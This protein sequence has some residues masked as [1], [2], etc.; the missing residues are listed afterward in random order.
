MSKPKQAARCLPLNFDLFHEINEYCFIRNFKNS[1]RQA[2]RHT[3]NPS[4]CTRC[5]KKTTW[6]GGSASLQTG[7]RVWIE[8]CK[9]VFII[10]YERTKILIVC[11]GNFWPVH[12]IAH[13]EGTTHVRWPCFPQWLSPITRNCIFAASSHSVTASLQVCL[14]LQNP[15]THTHTHTRTRTRTLL[16]YS[17]LLFLLLF[18]STTAIRLGLHPSTEPFTRSPGEHETKPKPET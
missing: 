14:C 15:N 9:Y 5:T 10:F 18:A 12:A 8:N 1:T 4:M 6:S 7:R 11:A 13:Q 16:F 2:G 3:L 17:D